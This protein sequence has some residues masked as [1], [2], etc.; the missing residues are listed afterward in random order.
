MKVNQDIVTFFLVGHYE[1]VSII[2]ETENDWRYLNWL[3]M[4]MVDCGE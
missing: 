1:G 2:E 4:I 3:I